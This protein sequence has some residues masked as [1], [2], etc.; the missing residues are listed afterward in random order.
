[1]WASVA[2]RGSSER[3]LAFSVCVLLFHV[4]NSIVQEAVFY[5]PG[6]H[7]TGLLTFAQALCVSL[8]ASGQLYRSSPG[9]SA[10]PWRRLVEA[11]RVPLRTYFMISLTNTLSVYLTNEASR[12]LSYSTQVVFKSSKLLFVWLVRYVA[13]ELPARLEAMEAAAASSSVENHNNR[14]GPYTD[15]S[16]D[17]DAAELHR[18]MAL[19][20]GE[21]IE[22]PSGSVAVHVCGPSNPVV[23]STKG[24][25]YFS[26]QS[27][28]A[29]AVASGNCNNN[30]SSRSLSHGAVTEHSK[31]V[32]EVAS[33]IAVVV[34]LI[35]FTYATTST[36]HAKDTEVEESWWPVITGVAGIVVALLC[37]ALMYLG[38]EKYCF[39]AHGAS[40]D[41][42][43][44]YVFL[45][46]SMNGLVSLLLSGSIADSMHFASTHFEFIFLMFVCS[47]CNYGGT[48][49]LL[50]IISEFNSSTATVVT[51][52]R[53]M[54]TVLCSYVV[55]P[56]P[57][58]V[59]HFIGVVL[60]M[61]GI[62]QYEEARKM[63][64][65]SA[66]MGKD[67]TVR[68]EDDV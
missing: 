47:L 25:A 31:L 48:F 37:D 44:F 56:K 61:G 50:R 68:D 18:C 22:K 19:A 32:R 38:E 35:V 26:P 41:E 7:H 3:L 63:H 36:P 51:S 11:R 6:F 58:S 49:F 5:I 57:F 12:L 24:G 40:H 53:K 43:Q 2:R 54:M 64:N 21:P 34:G 67:D 27:K 66:K 59:S 15:K 13:I 30:N 28:G 42:V 16:Q 39:M 55:Y 45:L 60:V 1:M 8:F 29:C 4:M 17:S 10:S 14:D 33:C 52:V 46:S 20:T 23:M 65:T 62:W 9:A